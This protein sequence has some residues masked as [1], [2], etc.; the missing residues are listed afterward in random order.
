MT[1]LVQRLRSSLG[2]DVSQAARE[3]LRFAIG[4]LEARAAK[5]AP[6]MA[7]AEFRCYSQFGE[8]GIIQWLVARVEIQSQTF[9]EFGVGDYREANTRFL[10]EHDNWRGLILDSGSAHVAYLGGSDLRWR[11]SIDARTAFITPENINALLADMAGDVGLLSIDI[12]GNDYWVWQAL[13]VAQPRI[14]VIEY[15]SLFGHQRAVTIPYEPDFDRFRAHPSGLYMG[16]SIAAL[17]WLAGRKGYRLVGSNSA[18][19]NA[20]FVREDVAGGL[21]ALTAAEGWRQS[22][23]RESRDERGRMTYVDSHADR[24]ALIAT[25][26]LLDVRTEEQPS[27]GDLA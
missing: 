2:G 17:H 10:L 9:I 13:T 11:N 23:F 7:E 19:N 3:Q 15:N 27:V 4:A 6:S 22:R 8:D 26:P 16:A 18:G 5:S 14:V 20:F 25:M 24:R 12:D 21:P 1:G